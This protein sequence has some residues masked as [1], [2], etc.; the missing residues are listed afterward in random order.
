MSQKSSEASTRCDDLL[1]VEH[2]AGAGDGRRPGLERR[3]REGRVVVLAHQ[4]ED[5]RPEAVG[6]V[7]HRP[8]PPKRSAGPPSTSESSAGD[9][10]GRVGTEE[11]IRPGLAQLLAIPRDRPRQPFLQA[12]QRRPVQHAPRL[13]G[14]E[15]LVEDLV[16]RLVPHVGLQVAPH[17]AEDQADQ[18]EDGD[19]ALVGEVDT[20]RPTCRRSPGQSPRPASC[21]RRRRPRRRSSRGSNVPSERITGRWPRRTERIVPG[22]IRFQFRSP[23]P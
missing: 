16:R 4:A 19:L 17:Q 3:G 2:P 10:P 8:W 20:P 9:R 15:V 22:T 14:A 21:R 13:G 11:P 6:L 23:P 18:V 1:G 7:T 5:L 12:E